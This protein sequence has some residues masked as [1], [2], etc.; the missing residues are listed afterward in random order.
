MAIAE[1]DAYITAHLE[2]FWV[3]AWVEVQL[4]LLSCSG[5]ICR[6]ASEAAGMKLKIHHVT[7]GDKFK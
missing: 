4:R 3:R 1:A 7:F 6:I 5:R 2:K